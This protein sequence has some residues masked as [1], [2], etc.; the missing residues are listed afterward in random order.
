MSKIGTQTVNALTTLGL[1]SQAEYVGDEYDRRN[2]I[3]S[4]RHKGRNMVT[5]PGKKG[6]G[7]DVT[8]SQKVLSLSEGDKYVDPG[9]GDRRHKMEQN[10]KKLYP[11]VFRPSSPGKRP[12]GAGSLFGTFGGGY[13]HKADDS[14]V[15][16]KADG[17]S[18]YE[19]KP[20]YI[21][22]NP[23]KKGTYGFPGLTIGKVSE[24]R[25]KADPYE[26]E[27][28]FAAIEEKRGAQRAMGPAFKASCRRGGAFDES[29]H[30]VSKVYS[31]D[32]QLPVRK[33]VVEPPRAPIVPWRPSN[34]G[35]HGFNCTKIIEYKEDPLDAKEKIR[36]QQRREEHAT[37][38]KTHKWLP[39]AGPKAMATRP[40]DLVV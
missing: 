7:P 1:F 26:G 10:K 5:C 32:R 30:G 2:N 28:R 16:T 29:E 8:F 18:R 27:R 31:L 13:E 37:Y 22:T 3:A 23:M 4:D 12:V 20:R 35:K 9:L 14:S 33:I 21:F 24:V 6:A 34:P 36:R 17:A 39:I 19:Q 15:K 40:I 11:G 38:N 25:D